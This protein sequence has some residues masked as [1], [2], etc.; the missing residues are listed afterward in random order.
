MRLRNIKGAAEKIESSKYNIKNPEKHKGKY[1]ELF[2]NQ[3]PIHIE[4]GMGKGRFLVEHAIKN[5][6]INFIGIEKFDSVLVHVINKLS[7]LEIPN[8]KVIRGDALNIDEYFCKEIDVIYLNFSDPWPKS[9]HEK[10]RLTHENFLRKYDSIFK[11]KPR[12]VLKTDN[13]KFFEY[14]VQSF[15]SYGYQ[16]SRLSLNLHNDD[17]DNIP[18]EYELKFHNKGYPIYMIDIHK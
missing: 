3:N 5:P 10:R 7:E 15:V 4:I 16:I 12:I 2:N 17:Y 1:K 18:T 6:D 13:R 14:S 8:L 9:R 11:S